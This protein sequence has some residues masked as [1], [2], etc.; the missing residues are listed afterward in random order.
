MFLD[1]NVIQSIGYYW[2]VYSL[3]V[4][5][6]SIKFSV[7]Y[8]YDL[9]IDHLQTA[10]LQSPSSHTCNVHYYRLS[11]RRLISSIGLGS[12]SWVYCNTEVTVGSDAELS[13][14]GSSLLA[15]CNIY[16]LRLTMTNGCKYV[17]Y[18]LHNFPWS[19]PKYKE[20]I[21]TAPCLPSSL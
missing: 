14:H 10:A 15:R 12:G 6:F 16:K 1:F 21:T 7:F 11:L 2:T 17:W 8:I 3:K 13:V 19:F 5:Y 18:W 9:H 4:C 20:R